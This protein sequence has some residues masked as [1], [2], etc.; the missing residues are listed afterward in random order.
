MLVD[1]ENLVVGPPWRLVQTFDAH[2]DDA[3]DTAKTSRV[4]W[5][6]ELVADSCRLTVIHYDLASDA[7]TQLY[8][9]WPMILSGLKTLVETGE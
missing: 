2:W 3:V 8:R 9:G 7:D 4:T 1:G 6:I 5:E